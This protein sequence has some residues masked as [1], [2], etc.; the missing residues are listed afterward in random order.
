MAPPTSSRRACATSPAATSLTDPEPVEPG[1][2]GE[3]AIEIDATAWRFPAGHRIR[4]AIATADFPNVWPT[5][6]LAT[7]DVHRGAATPSRIVLPVVPDEG[8]VAPPVFAPSPLPARHAATFERAPTWTRHP[9]RDHRPDGAS[10]IRLETAQSTPD[11]MRIER[12]SGC[13]SEVDPADPAHALARGWHRC[14]NE[15][16]GRCQRSPGPTW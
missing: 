15:R 13:V 8:P 7:L 11:G 3:L 14:R 9:R 1:V 2:V 10:T 4:I 12:D 5:P 6:E 16:D